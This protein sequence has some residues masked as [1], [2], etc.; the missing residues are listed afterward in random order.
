M[1][2]LAGEV[3]GVIYGG[4][5]RAAGRLVYAVPVARLQP[6]LDKLRER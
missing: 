5:P 4:D 2:N 1:F 3:I 6:L